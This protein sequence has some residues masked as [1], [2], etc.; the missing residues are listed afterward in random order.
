MKNREDVKMERLLMQAKSHLD[1]VKVEACRRCCED[2]TMRVVCLDKQGH[3]QIVL[4]A[5][6]VADYVSARRYAAI[7]FIEADGSIRPIS[8]RNTR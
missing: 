7:S 1:M 8:E 2:A 3:Y 6:Y 5:D 4:M